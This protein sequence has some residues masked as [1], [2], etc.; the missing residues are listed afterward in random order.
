M[1]EEQLGRPV[2]FE[3]TLL[4]TQAAIGRNPT[5]KAAPQLTALQVIFI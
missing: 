4:Y 5:L 3:R 1:M 2:N